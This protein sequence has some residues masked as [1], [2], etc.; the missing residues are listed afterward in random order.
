M[1][2]VAL[3]IPI[4]AL[5]IPIIAIVLNHKRKTQKDRIREMELQKELLELEVEKQNSRIKLLEAENKSLDR[6]IDL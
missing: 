5:S 3:L 1:E 4:I 2:Y 6:I